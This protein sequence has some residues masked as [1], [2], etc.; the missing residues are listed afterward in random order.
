MN[1]L[2]VLFIFLKNEGYSPNFMHFF[3]EREPFLKNERYS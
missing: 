1:I 3:E 2:Q